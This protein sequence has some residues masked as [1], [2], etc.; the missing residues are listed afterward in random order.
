MVGISSSMPCKKIG[1]W[2]NYLKDP[3]C[4]E[5]VIMVFLIQILFKYYE[6]LE[7]C[8]ILYY[9]DIHQREL[10]YIQPLFLN[11]GAW[12]LFVARIMKMLPPD[13]MLLRIC[14]WS[15][16][17]FVSLVPGK[18]FLLSKASNNWKTYCQNKN[19]PMDLS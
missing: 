17:Q 19:C 12:L 6:N 14:K 5:G 10:K 13:K 4:V 11:T 15:R 1:L 7:I 9:L 2:K 18:T 8:Y 3:P 16:F